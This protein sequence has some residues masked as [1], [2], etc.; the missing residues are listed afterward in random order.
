MTEETNNE[1]ASEQALNP[2]L[3]ARIAE[4][5]QKY[6]H[7]YLV[8]HKEAVAVLRK[9]RLAD[10]E[11]AQAARGDRKAKPMDFQRSIVRSCCL[12][13]D[14]VM[15]LGTGK[16]EYQ[17]A[18]LNGALEITDIPEAEIRKL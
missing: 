14:E 4:W 2:E 9:P 10:V 15:Q 16:D 13:A 1:E 6:K 18:L 7:I 17:F 11:K 5:K 12:H 8:R 3:E